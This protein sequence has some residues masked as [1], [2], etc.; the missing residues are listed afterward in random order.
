MD[1]IYDNNFLS[2]T[3]RHVFEDEQYYNV[4]KGIIRFDYGNDHGWW[5]RV[6]R[7]KAQ[8]KKLFS[9]GVYGSIAESL[10]KSILYRHE[11]L[12]S[13]PI[14]TK[15]IYSRSLPVNSEDRITRV[16]EKGNKQ[17]YI[18][19][20]ARWYD[21]NHNVK[22]KFFS[23]QKFGEEEAKLLALS[24][25]TKNHNKKPK[26]T[27]VPDNYHN[28]K[29]KNVLRSDVAILATI[30]SDRRPSASKLDKEIQ[31]HDPFAFE[32]EQFIVIHRAIERNKK[33]RVEKLKTFIAEH[34]RLFCELCHF[35]F[36]DAYPFLDNDIIEV[37][38]IIPLSLLKKSTET[39][40]SDLMLLCSNCHFAIHQGD[41]EENLLVAM[42]HFE[43]KFRQSSC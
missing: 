27:N 24:E 32:G 35:N 39:K 26:I 13:F 14:T 17:P 33:L 10:R 34:G 19:W 23:V 42:E 36:S 7:D 25:T 43:S 12:S 16:K 1:P 41:A 28:H 11:I 30:N 40:L 15:Y 8:F 37:H 9:D 22:T 38:H 21:V 18:A 20:K 2:E 31:E 6:T 4:P 3:L 5:V 29:G